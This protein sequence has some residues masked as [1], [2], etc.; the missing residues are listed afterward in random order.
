M[1]SSSDNFRASSMHGIIERIRQSGVSIIIY[2]PNLD[3]DTF[4]Q[5][6]LERDLQSFKKRADIIVANRLTTD[7]TDV[8]DKIYSRDLFG[9]DT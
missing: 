8:A 7:L 4:M 9:Q 2:E 1:K 6:P 3:A 5:I